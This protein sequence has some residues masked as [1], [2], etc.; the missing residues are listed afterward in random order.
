MARSAAIAMRAD[1]DDRAIVTF[2]RPAAIGSP[3]AIVS[4]GLCCQ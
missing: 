4:E 3:L 1:V 2:I